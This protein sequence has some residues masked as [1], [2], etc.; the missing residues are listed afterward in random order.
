MKVLWITNI[1]LPEAS[2]L[3]TGNGDL[4]GSGGWLVGSAKALCE[5]K[6]IS[7]SI[8]TPSKFVSELKI[9]KGERIT[10]YVLPFGKGNVRYNPKY[11]SFFKIIEDKVH[12]D[13]IHIHGTEFSHGLSYVKACGSKNVVASIQGMTSVIANYYYAGI[14]DLEVLRNI[15]LSDICLQRSLFRKANE[16]KVSGTS[17][18][19]LI[20][21]INHVIGRTSWDEAWTWAINPDIKYHF[22]NETLRPEFY[23]GKWSLESCKKHSIFMSQAKNSMKGL[24][25]ILRA[26][27]LVLREY[28]DTKLIIP[29]SN[30][31]RYK[32]FRDYLAMGSYEKILVKII[33]ENMLENA[34]HFIGSLNAQEM[35]ENYL[36]ANV[37]VLC[38]SIENSP[39]SLGEAQI[40]GTPVISSYVGGTCDMIEEKTT[41]LLYR[42][43]D[44]AMLAK[45]I[46]GV[47]R[48]EYDLKVMSGNEM[49]TAL[50][51][52]SADI[53][54][55]N[56][57][58][59]YNN[60]IS[61]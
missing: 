13:V 23:S 28:P 15:T 7:L 19:N 12:P 36:Q 6:D 57:I 22:C 35:K 16:L 40:L 11:E 50:A 60:I 59:I 42:F 1:L 41:G 43:D 29:G 31:L 52:H 58:S 51:R 33:K 34:I 18:V 8:A 30:I 39:N 45:K 20:K 55:R 2:R 14:S 9:I 3:L 27:P 37:F 24:H 4:K 17:E 53:N 48:G 21:S 38:S 56:L 32:T 44:Y 25:I 47:F 46:C 5:E 49:A 61:N 10:Y 26:L 54:N